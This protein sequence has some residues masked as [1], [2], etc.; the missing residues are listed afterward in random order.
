MSL[1]RVLQDKIAKIDGGKVRSSQSYGS[2]SV[3]YDG[4][5]ASA[6]SVLLPLVRVATTMKFDMFALVS[7]LLLP[8]CP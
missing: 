5:W 7:L 8:T 3:R 2:K 1:L 6:W 4:A